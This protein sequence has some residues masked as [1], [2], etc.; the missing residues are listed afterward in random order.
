MHTSL[1][2]ERRPPMAQV[3]QPDCR[4]AKAADS[5]REAPGEP[6]RMLHR[7]VDMTEHQIVVSPA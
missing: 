1:Q 4:Q 2:S 6:L 7:A 5:V 3:M